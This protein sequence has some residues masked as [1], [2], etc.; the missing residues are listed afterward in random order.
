ML[1]CHELDVDVFV[2]IKIAIA[3]NTRINKALLW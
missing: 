1:V 3:Y 2:D